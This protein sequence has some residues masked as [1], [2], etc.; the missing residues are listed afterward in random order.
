M[1]SSDAPVS[2][3]STATFAPKDTIYASVATTGTG[4]NASL[5]A[6]WIFK[7]TQTVDSTALT[8]SPTGPSQNEFHV[9]KPTGW[10]VGKYKVVIYLDGRQVSEKDFEVKK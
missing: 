1:L 3:L 7:D 6:K 9:A 4:T 8:I 10:P 5:A 2:L